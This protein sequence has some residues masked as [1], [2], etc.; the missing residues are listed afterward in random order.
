M[1]VINH[2]ESS[3]IQQIIM[4]H[5]AGYD[6][7]G[8]YY[9]SQQG[10][11]LGSFFGKL[12]RMAIPAVGRTIK[13]VAGIAKPHLQKA[14]EELIAAGSKRLLDKISQPRQRKKRR[15]DLPRERL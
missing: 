14:G 9:Y 12:L 11:G 2:S 13:G 8:Y 15:S 7:D 1:E 10:E 5:G 4:Q 6:S 3:P